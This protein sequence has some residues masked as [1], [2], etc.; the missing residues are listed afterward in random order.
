[1]ELSCAILPDLSFRDWC[2]LF[3]ILPHPIEALP[4]AIVPEGVVLSVV[5]G[6]GRPCRRAALTRSRGPSNAPA[7]ALM[8]FET[9]YYHSTKSFANAICWNRNSSRWQ[10]ASCGKDLQTRSGRQHCARRGKMISCASEGAAA[11]FPDIIRRGMQ[12]WFSAPDTLVVS[13]VYLYSV[14]VAGGS[15]GSMGPSKVP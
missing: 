3:G 12:R 15:G 10:S 11:V 13:L 5:S 14:F 6:L 2:L 4:V 9:L 1:L 8:E 7:R